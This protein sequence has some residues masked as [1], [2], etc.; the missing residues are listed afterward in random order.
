MN[1]VDRTV[2]FPS[3]VAIFIA[4]IAIVTAL[5]RANASVSKL[6]HLS[7]TAWVHPSGGCPLRF[8]IHAALHG[9][10]AEPSVAMRR[11]ELLCGWSA[12]R[13]AVSFSSGVF[14]GPWRVVPKVIRGILSRRCCSM[15]GVGVSFLSDRPG[16]RLSNSLSRL[17]RWESS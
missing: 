17:R 8:T 5:R 1:R 11:L 3:C 6:E 15:V 7:L 2:G 13:L 14:C 9:D 10:S 16:I 4:R 12:V